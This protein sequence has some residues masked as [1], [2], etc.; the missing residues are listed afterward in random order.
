L[1]Q[2][3]PAAPFSQYSF[4]GE[5]DENPEV[6]ADHHYGGSRS[7]LVLIPTSACD[8]APGIPGVYKHSE[9]NCSV[10]MQWSVGQMR[11][12]V[13]SDIERQYRSREV[14]SSQR[15]H[16]QRDI[17]VPSVMPIYKREHNE[18]LSSTI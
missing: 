13:E 5:L 16:T 4:T 12:N 7:L 15:I 6:F 10:R 3:S 18:F 11:L 17:T 9:A 1:A 8:L 14:V 2:K